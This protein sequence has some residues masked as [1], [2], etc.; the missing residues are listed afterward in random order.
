MITR[1]EFERSVLFLQPED[2]LRNR[3]QGARKR[4]ECPALLRMLGITARGQRCLDIGPGHGETLDGWQEQGAARIGFVDHDPW[5]Y[6]HN[7][8]K[9]GVEGW[10]LNHFASLARLPQGCWDLIWGY[11]C[12]SAARRRFRLPGARWRFGRWLRALDRLAA[13][14]AVVALCPHWTAAGGRRVIEDVRD[15]WMAQELAAHG[16]RALPYLAEHNL[17]PCYPCTWVKGR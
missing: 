12:V 10:Q 7:R 16:Y 1:E 6:Q 14:G 11:G 5:Y 2:F 9:P 13:P 8:L 15:H 3:A 4:G 17:E